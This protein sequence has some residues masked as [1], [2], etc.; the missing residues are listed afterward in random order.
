MVTRTSLIVLSIVIPGCTSVLPVAPVERALVNDVRTIVRSQARSEWT[1]DRS[2]LDMIAPAVAWS[3]CQVSADE[4][5]RSLQWLDGA[6]GDEE[7]ALGGRGLPAADLWRRADKDLGELDDLLELSRIRL[8]LA[9]LHT[10]AADDCPFWLEADPEFSG[11][12]GDADRFIL[13][14][15]S[16]GGVTLHLRGSALAF[17]G[18][19][20]GRVLVGGGLSDRLTLAAG[21][22]IGGT[23]RFDEDG[24]VTGVLG[25]ALPV[26][27]RFV[28]AGSV[29]DLELAATT[30]L[31]GARGW[32][33]GVRA[34]VAFGVVTPRVGGA[35]SPSAVFWIGYELHPA[36]G[37]DEAFHVI[38]LG[39]RIGVDVDP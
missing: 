12:Q 23:G 36:R 1:V 34:A 8:A 26:L 33:P 5:A 19:G 4:R 13:L 17:G 35:F 38:G 15:E 30:F 32:P 10:R 31:G 25:A 9:G 3:A 39:T 21:F 20:A 14:L 24:E 2:A 16:R 27:L 37:P 7:E 29:I 22:E 6:I 28:D 18:G 11:M